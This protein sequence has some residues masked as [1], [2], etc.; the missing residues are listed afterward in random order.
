MPTETFS[1]RKNPKTVAN[2]ALGIMK[3]AKL[4]GFKLKESGVKQQG[5]AFVATARWEE[6]GFFGDSAELR[7]E[8]RM[9]YSGGTDVVITSSGDRCA[10]LAQR[11][12]KSL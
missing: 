10:R 6:G 7:V 1:V 11:L 3:R 12:R 5:D 4:A 9:A 8:A 2:K